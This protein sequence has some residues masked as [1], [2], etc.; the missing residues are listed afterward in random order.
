MRQLVADVIANN[1]AVSLDRFEEIYGTFLCE[2]KLKSGA[3][4][5][6]DLLPDEM[7]SQDAA[8]TL[9]VTH[10]GE[11]EAVNA[12]VPNQCIDFSPKLTIIFGENASGKSGY[13]RVLK[14][15]AAVRSAEPVLPDL[16]SGA[17]ANEVPSAHVTF[18]IG[19]EEKTIN[20][21]N[22][23]GVSP[24]T[25]IDVF[26]SK[27]SLMHVDADLTYVYMPG[28]LA[29]FPLVQRGI[30][31]VRSRLD[32]EIAALAAKTNPFLSRAKRDSVVYPVLQQ[33]GA[34]TDIEN[35]RKLATLSEEERQQI[36]TL[37]AEIETLRSNNPSAQLKLGETQLKRIEE[38]IGCLT[39]LSTFDGAAY[40]QSVQNVNSA[41]EAY[42]RAS[43][44]SFAGLPIPGVLEDEWKRFIQAGEEYLSR[45][46]E[47]ATYPQDNDPCI[48][49]RQP[50]GRDAVVLLKKYRDYCNAEFRSELSGAQN[51]ADVVSAAVRFASYAQLAQ[52][53]GDLGGDA[54]V[55][56]AEYV[57]ELGA[58]L[59]LGQQFAAACEA[60]APFDWPD[61]GAQT[62]R[63]KSVAESVKQRLSGII[64]ALKEQSGERDQKLQTRTAELLTLEARLELANVLK[65][66]ESFVNEAKW[67]QDGRKQSA[68]FQG[69]FRSLTDASKIATQN[70]LNSDF[71]VRFTDECKQLK[72][73]PVKLLFPGKE[74]KV[75]RKKTVGTTDRRPSEVLSEGE[76]KVIALADFLAE[77]SLKPVAPIVFD[78]PITSL[79]YKRMSDVVKRISALSKQRQVIVF[80]HNIWFTTELLSEFEKHPQDCSYYDVARDGGRIGIIAKGNHPRMDTYKSLRGSINS[81]L[82]DAGKLKGES[83]AALIEKGYD[84]VRNICEVIVETELF[85]GITQRYQPNVRMMSLPN[86]KCDHLKEAIDTMYPIYEKCCRIILSHSQ[87]LETL[88]V[89][90]SLSDL[91]EDWKIVEAARDAFTAAK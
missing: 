68:K 65:E 49:C 82:Q 28:E 29:R 54:F 67:V 15:A 42:E 9:T 10:L 63:M 85:L 38:A 22:E 80:T 84:F 26:D 31:Q 45:H 23:A 43:Q 21:Q 11:L 25:R 1:R 12:L 5:S 4:V 89:R 78:D 57:T 7:A 51:A 87:P 3:S 55:V 37:K 30:D 86:I 77:V 61:R 34:S 44:H 8:K 46:Q 69:I 72:T 73:P 50:L 64:A 53:L 75:S 62:S 52:Q 35:V 66:V 59:K 13:V 32:A 39:A 58:V 56:T 76:Q 83:Q 24:L 60:Y 90:P 17:H 41:R 91:K 40:L 19:D 48:Y 6:V 16:I 27:A 81:L 2:K 18:Q 70:L 74:G 14:R 79:D 20:W 47:A 71:G 36:G 33:L 88:S